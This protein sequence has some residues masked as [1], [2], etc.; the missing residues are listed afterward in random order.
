MEDKKIKNWMKLFRDP[1]ESQRQ[2]TRL[3]ELGVLLSELESVSKN[4]SVYQG[5]EKT[6]FFK[7]NQ[8][9]V[10]SALK[11]EQNSILKQQKA[12]LEE[13]QH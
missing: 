3:Q 11:R 10:K 9:S 8:S 7:V 13:R 1:N 2:Q 4:V 12:A 5:S 6:V